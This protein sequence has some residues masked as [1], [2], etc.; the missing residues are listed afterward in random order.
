LPVVELLIASGADIS[1][2]DIA[3]NTVVHLA[4]YAG[5]L[6]TVKAL[7]ER[8]LADINAQNKDGQTAAALATAKGFAEIAD[9]LNTRSQQTTN[10]EVDAIP[11]AQAPAVR[12]GSY[13]SFTTSSLMAMAA[14]AAGES[15]KN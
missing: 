8:F 1:E 14:A 4:A 15:S 2:H 3:G 5:H 10:A 12:R 7:V 9:F 13:H 11:M 6:P